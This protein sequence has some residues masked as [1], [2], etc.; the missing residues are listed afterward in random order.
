MYAKNTTM[1]PSLTTIKA[2]WLRVVK[3]HGYNPLT[4]TILLTHYQAL[5][6]VIGKKILRQH[7]TVLQ[8]VQQ[9]DLRKD[10]KVAKE[11]LLKSHLVSDALPMVL[12]VGA[13][14]L[15]HTITK[16]D[17]AKRIIN[18]ASRWSH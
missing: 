11:D 5:T 15:S 14:L 17:Q 4:R 12:G 7:L 3:Y 2:E 13:L 18:L 10:I 1:R 6:Q 16:T 9:T 8:T